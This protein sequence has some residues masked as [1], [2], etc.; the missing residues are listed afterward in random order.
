MACIVVALACVFAGFMTRQ[1]PNWNAALIRPEWWQVILAAIAIGV[2]GYQAFL[3]RRSVDAAKTSADALINSERAW[4]VADF[5]P[6]CAKFGGTWCRPIAGGWTMMNPEELLKGEHLNHLLKLTN[7]GRTPARILTFE[8]GHS[9]L[10]D[11]GINGP[12][13]EI[14]KDIEN[15]EFDRILGGGESIQDTEI[16]VSQLVNKSI[17]KVGDSK[18]FIGFYGLIKYQHVFSNV[19]VEEVPFRYL[20]NPFTQQFT[21]MPQPKSEKATENPN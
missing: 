15:N 8:L 6:I 7:M 11:E 14:V 18:T 21:R 19:D 3:T 5:V 2:I 1:S 13:G 9:P 4:V 10:G 17:K 20:Y 16:N 12:I